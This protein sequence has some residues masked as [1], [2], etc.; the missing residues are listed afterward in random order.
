MIK[1][2]WRGVR[3]TLISTMMVISVATLFGCVGV[4]LF[5]QPMIKGVVVALITPSLF[6][7]TA[8]LNDLVRG[9]RNR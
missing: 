2:S 3:E 6:I 4:W 7:L 5:D 1:K 8:F 9:L